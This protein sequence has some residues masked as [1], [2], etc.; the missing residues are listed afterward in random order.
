MFEALGARVLAGVV[1]LSM[2]LF[3]TFQGNDPRFGSISHNKSGSYVYL[4]AQLQ[5]AF[6]NDFPSIF[7]SGTSIPVYYNLE[8]RN[9]SNLVL[10]K[11]LINQVNYDPASGIYAIIREGEATSYT[12]SLELVKRELSAFEYALPYQKSWKILNVKLEAELPKVIFSQLNKELD[13]MVLWKY[14]KPSS[15]AQIDLRAN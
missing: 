2:L 8:V 15:K 4:K 11:R 3:S 12:E 13:L 10:R 7:A 1:S 14:R 6:D 9:G 5:S